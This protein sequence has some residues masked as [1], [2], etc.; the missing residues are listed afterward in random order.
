MPRKR[1]LAIFL[2]LAIALAAALALLWPF[3]EPAAPQAA[4]AQPAAPSAPPGQIPPRQG[5]GVARGEPFAPR[6]WTPPQPATAPASQ[7]AAPPAPPPMPYRYAGRIVRQGVEEVLLARGDE[8]I[9]VSEGV[10][11]AGGYRVETIGKE[12]ITLRYLPMNVAQTIPVL[13]LPADKP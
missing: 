10:S 12:H 11:L 8:L 3:A 2:V 1:L 4:V 5:L 7:A 13:T 6:T 9:P